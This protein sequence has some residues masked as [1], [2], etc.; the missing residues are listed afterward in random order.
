V[1][2][3]DKT[4]QPGGDEWQ[5]ALGVADT[6]RRTCRELQ[7]S[8]GREWVRQVMS[9]AADQMRTAVLWATSHDVPQQSKPETVRPYIVAADAT[10]SDAAMVSYFLNFLRYE[11]LVNEGMAE[12]MNRRLQAIEQGMDLLSRNLRQELGFD[13]YEAVAT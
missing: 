9:E 7:L 5:S 11:H 13:P 3:A 2:Q 10:R 6:V 1:K 12:D 4:V 8:P